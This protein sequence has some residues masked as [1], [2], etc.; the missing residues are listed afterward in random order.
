MP[1]VSAG[2]GGEVSDQRALDEWLRD[3]GLPTLVPVRRWSDDLPRRVAPLQVFLSTLMVGAGLVVYATLRVAATD[4][5][6]AAS[7]AD[8]DT[9]DLPELLVLAAV[10]ALVVAV[11][12]LLAWLVHRWL[13]GRPRR[14]ATPAAWAV[15]L[16]ATTAVVPVGLLLAPVTS[17]WSG[18]A[19]P[20]AGLGGAFLFVWIGGAAL[21]L[22]TLRAVL[23]N[24]GAVRHMSI[25]LPVI[26]LLVV[27]ALFSTELWQM[28]DTLSWA[29]LFGV[30]AV[31]A[32]MGAA[33][34]LPAVGRSALDAPP[35]LDDAHRRSLLTG[36]GLPP[37]PRP[38]RPLN[39]LQR[40]NVVLVMLVAQLVLGGVFAIVQAALLV[41]LGDVALTQETLAAW[42]EHAPTTAQIGRTVLPWSVNLLKTASLLAMIATLSFVISAV[43]DA[44]YREHFFDPLLREVHE[45]LA[46]YG[47]RRS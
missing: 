34:V 4:P 42:L 18:V 19:L 37:E 28:T 40:G 15:N 41:L 8:D 16:V 12:A 31:L 23:R 33:V 47:A 21:L 13:R 24:V 27:F 39:R 35:A 17:W 36:L 22:W 25:A 3:H 14:R 2:V 26:L 46:V 32:L 10:A 11:P 20:V 43:T 29:R 1:F 5:E 9:F 30:G 44:Q 38:A 7:A 45:A 6:V